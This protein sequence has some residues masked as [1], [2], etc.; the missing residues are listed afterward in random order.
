MPG[1]ADADAALESLLEEQI[2]YYRAIAAEY[3]GHALLGADGELEAALEAFAP[4]GHVLELA[5]GTGIWTAHLARHADSLTA[6]DAAPEMLA[7]A[8]ARVADERVR[9]IRSD[10]FAWEPDGRYDAVVFG[11]WLSHVPLERFERFWTLVAEC[12]EPHGRVFFLDDAHRTAEELLEGESGARVCRRLNDGSAH[13][14]FKVPHTPQQL[15]R[16]LAQLGWRITVTS[17]SGPFFWGEG[18]AP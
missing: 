15:E 10:I 8:R 2:G 17:T 11:F 7:I 5:C 1:P 18:T 13:Q 9:F 4:R 6:I 3:E 12:L 14:I 16:R